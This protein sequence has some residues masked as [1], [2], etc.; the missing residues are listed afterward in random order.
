MLLKIQSSNIIDYKNDIKKALKEII[1][2]CSFEQTKNIFR[3]LLLD[4]YHAWIYHKEDKSHM[5]VITTINNDF[6]T[7]KNIFCV[8]GIYAPN[9]TNIN[10]LRECV[11]TLKPFA[12]KYNCDKY[13]FLMI[14]PHIW[15]Y[16]DELNPIMEAR[17][18]QVKF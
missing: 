12:K 11:E 13:E 18:C 17:Y 9:G 10:E 15:H 14:N 8:F 3:N 5:M 4:V 1:P 2:E 16:I 7:D 6:F